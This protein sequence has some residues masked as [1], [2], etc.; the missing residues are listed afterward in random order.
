MQSRML[1][2]IRR[3]PGGFATHAGIRFL[4]V[5]EYLCLCWSAEPLL[6]FALILCGTIFCGAH[7]RG[8]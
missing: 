3:N 4:H 5:V 8:G 1:N 2:R 7:I 6:P